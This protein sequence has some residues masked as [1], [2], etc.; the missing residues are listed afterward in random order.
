MLL[1]YIIVLVAYTRKV[2][3]ERADVSQAG[4]GRYNNEG[5]T[6]IAIDNQATPDLVVF[7]FSN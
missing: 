2:R 7:D 6:A 5:K 4:Y 1:V 3:T